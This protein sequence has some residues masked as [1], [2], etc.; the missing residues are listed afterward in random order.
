MTQTLPA[1]TSK[2][3]IN[4]ADLPRLKLG[5]RPLVLLGLCAAALALFLIALAVGSVNIPLDQIVHV[6]LGGEAEKA[7][8]TNIVLKVR[9]PRAITAVLAG[10]ALSVGGLLMQ[11]F[12]RNPLADPF[13]LGISS[14]ASL[15]VALV[16]LSA[17]TA[18][19]TFLMSVGLMGDFALAFAA[20]VGAALTMLMVL[21]VARR[22]ANPTVLLVLGLMFGY[23]TGAMVSLLLHFAV[24]ERVQAY[25]NWGFG[26]F[27]A[28][29][30]DQLVILAP[31]VV[32]GLAAAF[33]QSKTL[34]ALMLGENYARS[35]GLDVRRARVGV[36]IVTGLLAGAV[37]AFC[38]PIGFIG[39][40]VPHVAR[41]LVNSSDH[42][43]LI[44]AVA[45][46]GVCVAL[47]A[48]VVA[49]MPFTSLTLPLNAVTAL[50]GAPV[51][52][53]LLL[54]GNNRVF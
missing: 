15:G 29:T 50:F 30:W 33:W 44:P 37:T 7:S 17:G 4:A 23:L 2:P 34:N 9:L 25:V 53:W 43:M 35:M 28:V 14:G 46:V 26:T 42:R 3:A 12:F 49:E 20:S 31:V 5:I 11:T 45:L 38:G 39:V 1:R 16:V 32:I 48:A 52:M 22:V 54:R 36:V 6:L 21:G 27:N 13:I 51:V 19:A 41:A 18:G 10:A 47:A 24:P 8:W 40:A